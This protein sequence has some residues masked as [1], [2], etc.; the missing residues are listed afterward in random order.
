MTEKKKTAKEIT[1]ERRIKA[2]ELAIKSQKGHAL[3]KT[4]I[5]RAK[6]ILT[7]INEQ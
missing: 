4:L 6:E 1:Y 7:F 5:E 2:M 3:T